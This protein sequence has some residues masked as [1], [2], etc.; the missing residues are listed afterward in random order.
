MPTPHF[1]PRAAWI[2]LIVLA[3]LAAACWGLPLLGLPD[4]Q[5]PDWDFLSAAPSL[6]SAHWFGT[7]AIGRD[8]LARVLAGGRLSL[9]IGF[10]A[11]LIALVIGVSYGAVAGYA[12][13]WTERG[14]VRAL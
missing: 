9:T 10:L 11:S 4:P 7:D 13:G 6:A 5:R 3:A 2:C 1:L 12:G 14:M 8:I